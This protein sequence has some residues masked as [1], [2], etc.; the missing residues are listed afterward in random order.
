MT[1]F[2]KIEKKDPNW[3]FDSG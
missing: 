1:I 2:A 3:I